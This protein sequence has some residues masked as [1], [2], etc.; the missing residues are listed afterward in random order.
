MNKQTSSE[1]LK[2]EPNSAPS[3]PPLAKH[4]LYTSV[5]IIVL[6]VFVLIIELASIILFI[7][8]QFKGE[9]VIYFQIGVPCII[10]IALWMIGISPYGL[11]VIIDKSNNTVT[12]RG[13][14]ILPCCCRSVDFVNF[15]CNINEIKGFRLNHYSK[16]EEYERTES[17]IYEVI[18]CLTRKEEVIIRKIDPFC[19][20]HGLENVPDQFTRWIIPIKPL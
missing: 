15:T 10:F 14:S 13:K 19:G 3:P 17:R 20:D 11:E 12:F 2:I 6:F 5:G 18:A 7:V 1:Y 9:V 8:Y 16:G 4:L